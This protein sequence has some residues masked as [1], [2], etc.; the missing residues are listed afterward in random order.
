MMAFAIV[1][2]LQVNTLTIHFSIKTLQN[3]TLIDYID[4]FRVLV[5]SSSVGG[6]ELT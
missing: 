3:L 2:T 6:K 1:I 4:P 5:G